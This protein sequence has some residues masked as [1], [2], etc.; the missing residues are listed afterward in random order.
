M[1]RSEIR[2]PEC[3]EQIG[4]KRQGGVVRVFRPVNTTTTVTA[5]GPVRHYTC[6]ACR[7]RWSF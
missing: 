7:H 6:P 2:C 5:T 1:S 3:G 4:W